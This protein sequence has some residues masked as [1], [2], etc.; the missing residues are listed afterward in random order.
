MGYLLAIGL[1]G[2]F[3]WPRR[4]ALL[5]VLLAVLAILALILNIILRATG[6]ADCIPWIGLD[7]ND[8]SSSGNTTTG[9]GNTTSSDS[10]RSVYCGNKIATYITHGLMILWL[11]SRY[12][13]N[14]YAI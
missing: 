2:L 3:A 5:F 1:L 13:S 12:K 8:D 11:V 4:H 9:T 7:D 6:N 14:P 10:D